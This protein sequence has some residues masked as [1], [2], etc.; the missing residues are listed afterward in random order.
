MCDGWGSETLKSL[1]KSLKDLLNILKRKLNINVVIEN[2]RWD[3]PINLFSV[4]DI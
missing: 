2:P 4:Q 3:Y 1:P